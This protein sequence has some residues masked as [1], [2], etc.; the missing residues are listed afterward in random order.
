MEYVFRLGINS[1][2]RSLVLRPRRGIDAVDQLL[3]TDQALPHLVQPVEHTYQTPR[4]Y[5]LW[6]RFPFPLRPELLSHTDPSTAKFERLRFGLVSLPFELVGLPRH[7]VAQE[8]HRF[9][10]GAG[11]VDTKQVAVYPT[12]RSKDLGT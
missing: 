4:P 7:V 3:S 11:T 1:W 9:N 6:M 8:E 5:S 12:V 2:F 10:I